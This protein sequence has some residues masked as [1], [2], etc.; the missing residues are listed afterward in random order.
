MVSSSPVGYALVYLLIYPTGLILMLRMVRVG[1]RPVSTE[2][3][4][5]AARRIPSPVVIEATGIA[6]GGVS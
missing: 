4:E 3:T 5:I 1:P 6:T 2:S